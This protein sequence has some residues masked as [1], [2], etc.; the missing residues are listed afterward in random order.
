MLV[1]AHGSSRSA[2]LR[3][4]WIF[5]RPRYPSAMFSEDVAA[6]PGRRARERVRLTDPPV[7]GSK[8]HEAAGEFAVCRSPPSLVPGTVHRRESVTN[9]RKLRICRGLLG[10]PLMPHRRTFLTIRSANCRAA[11]SPL[12]RWSPS[13]SRP[14]LCQ[15]EK[16]AGTDDQ[17]LSRH[18]GS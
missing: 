14:P 1:Y 3:A 13:P 17:H 11:H 10:E 7:F 5:R 4:E 15:V 8:Q 2:F 16:R 12:R 18:P 6:R 9:L